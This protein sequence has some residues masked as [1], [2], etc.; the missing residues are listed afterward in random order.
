MIDF[1]SDERAKL[2]GATRYVADLQLDGMLVGGVVRSPHP[3]ARIVRIDTSR[4]LAIPGVRAVLTGA[5][6]PQVVFGPTAVKDWNILARERAPRSR[7]STNRSPRS[8]IP[9]WRCARTHPRSTRVPSAIVRC[10]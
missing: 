1:R 6:V 4:A 5:D 10:T 7:S 8:S 9:S 2:S 3:H